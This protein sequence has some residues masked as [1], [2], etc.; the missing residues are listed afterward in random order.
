M[1]PKKT[2]ALMLG[3]LK[4]AAR[5]GSF[6]LLLTSPLLTNAFL[7]TKLNY[8]MVAIAFDCMLVL[9]FLLSFIGADTFKKMSHGH[10]DHIDEA[11]Y[12]K[13]FIQGVLV[14]LGLWMFVL[15]TPV[16][17]D[18][19]WKNKGVLVW[20]DH[21]EFT[22]VVSLLLSLGLFYSVYWVEQL[23]KKHFKPEDSSGDSSAE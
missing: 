18:E 6:L 22:D 17:W 9:T 15:V 8:D 20:V 14:S 4:G 7:G 16:K 10:Y 19:T 3:I 11:V 5:T 13:N 23:K 2:D 21:I 12:R 1:R